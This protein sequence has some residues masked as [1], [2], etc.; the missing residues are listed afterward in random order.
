MCVVFFLCC[1]LSFHFHLSV[2]SCVPEHW[3]FSQFL[4]WLQSGGVLRRCTKLYTPHPHT[5]RSCCRLLHT[6]TQTHMH[7][8]VHRQSANNLL[9]LVLLERSRM[10]LDGGCVY[11]V[12]C[13]HN[14]V[15]Y[16]VTLCFNARSKR[17]GSKR[18][19]SM[20]GSTIRI[21]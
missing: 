8:P 7:K 17:Y 16:C 2:E 1:F 14:A 19:Q 11:C 12:A 13:K 15:V 10:V 20:D 6:T 3:N 18:T 5:Y 4:S 21:S 9:L